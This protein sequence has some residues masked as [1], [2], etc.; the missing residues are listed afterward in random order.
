MAKKFFKG[1]LIFTI[2]IIVSYMLTIIFYPIPKVNHPYETKIVS[3]EEKLIYSQIR[4]ENGTYT[5]LEKISDAFITTLI[6]IEDQ[7]FYSHNGV[8]YKRII[9]SSITNIKQIISSRIP[10]IIHPL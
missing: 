3:V 4:E 2:I 6:E 10:I 8:D 5:H 9:A 1:T 7:H